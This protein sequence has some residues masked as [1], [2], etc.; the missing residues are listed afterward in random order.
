MTNKFLKKTKK[1]KKRSNL[2][3]YDSSHSGI[4]INPSGSQKPYLPAKLNNFK[5]FDNAK[6]NSSTSNHDLTFTER[7]SNILD[8]GIYFSN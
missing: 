4:K 7:D 2:K 5:S 1:T 6:A 3:N 8:H